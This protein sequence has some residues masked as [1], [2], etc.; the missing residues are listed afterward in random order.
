M[1]TRLQPANTNKTTVQKSITKP[2]HSNVTAPAQLH[3]A[4]SDGYSSDE[5]KVAISNQGHLLGLPVSRQSYMRHLSDSSQALRLSESALDKNSERGLA[6]EHPSYKVPT[7]SDFEAAPDNQKLDDETIVAE[8]LVNSRFEGTLET[9]VENFDA[10]T[11]PDKTAAEYL[12]SS[13]EM[14]RIGSQKQDHASDKPIGET[15]QHVS[16]GAPAKH[17]SDRTPAKNMT[18]KRVIEDVLSRSPARQLSD[19]LSAENERSVEP[20]SDGSSVNNALDGSD[21]IKVSAGPNAVSPMRTKEKKPG[22]PPANQ[23]TVS[24][25]SKPSHISPNFTVAQK[26][27]L[28]HNESQLEQN[29]DPTVSGTST[30]PPVDNAHSDKPTV[31][32]FSRRDSSENTPVTA[33]SYNRTSRTSSRTIQYSSPQSRKISRDGVMHTVSPQQSQIKELPLS[34]STKSNIIDSSGNV[35][36]RPI[37]GPSQ[38]YYPSTDSVT[39]A[40]QQL[41]TISLQFPAQAMI[42]N[43][44]MKAKPRNPTEQRS[45]I[46]QREHDAWKQLH[47]KS[48]QIAGHSWSASPGVKVTSSDP[49]ELSSQH[50]TIHKQ[51]GFLDPESRRGFA[52]RGA[53]LRSHSLEVIHSLSQLSIS[54]LQPRL[55]KSANDLSERVSSTLDEELHMPSELTDTGKIDFFA[56]TAS[57]SVGEMTKVVKDVHTSTSHSLLADLLADLQSGFSTDYVLKPVDNSTDFHEEQVRPLSMVES[58]SLEAVKALSK[59][60]HDLGSITLEENKS[61]ALE[62]KKMRALSIKSTQLINDVTPVTEHVEN[63]ENTVSESAAGKYNLLS[64]SAAK[65][66]NKPRTRPDLLPLEKLNKRESTTAVNKYEQAEVPGHSS[67]S[68]S[69]L[70]F[71]SSSDLSLADKGDRVPSVAINSQLE[72]T[73]KQS[74][75]NTKS[76]NL[77]VE[78]GTSALSVDGLFSA[79]QT[80]V[81][82]TRK[83][84]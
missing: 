65:I 14:L 78:V 28:F 39:I 66:V 56:D 21:A 23:F 60:S 71:F 77:P 55:S 51:Q 24:G 59:S 64:S 20:V 13:A 33:F 75:T 5:S 41:K 2:L 62:L 48:A 73:S 22:A 35:F 49:P 36:N 82:Q 54:S 67:S 83:S 68:R 9:K 63:E 7:E 37:T 40:G 38:G 31:N 8:Q 79:A 17:V 84:W 15:Q 53:A 10:E 69:V 1:D 50:A 46:Q 34:F 76:Q 18:M 72:V 58:V 3:S 81:G 74:T 32:K 27:Q 52:R 45:I 70:K 80:A 19:G 57:L 25:H 29:V 61:S 12:S 4:K 30:S 6:E 47:S 43:R 26:K 42:V 16:Y 11:F 44:L